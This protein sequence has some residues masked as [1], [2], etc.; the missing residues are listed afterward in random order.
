MAPP[1]EL[2]TKSSVWVKT[3]GRIRDAPASSEANAATVKADVQSGFICA[4]NEPWGKMVVWLAVSSVRITRGLLLASSTPLSGIISVITRPERTTKI[5]AD[6]GWI[7]KD[8][9][10]Q[11][12][13]L[14]SVWNVFHLQHG[15]LFCKTRDT[16]P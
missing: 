9:M 8:A 16:H 10:V 12:L 15:S 5:S 2:I 7:C 3:C 14:L 1:N 13:C 6:R 11:A 4:W